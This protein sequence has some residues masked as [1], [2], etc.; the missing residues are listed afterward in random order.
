MLNSKFNPDDIG[1]NPLVSGMQFPDKKKGGIYG[2]F[3]HD[4]P[5]VVKELV[6]NRYVSNKR[7]IREKCVLNFSSRE[8]AKGKNHLFQPKTTIAMLEKKMEKARNIAAYDKGTDHENDMVEEVFIFAKTIDRWAIPLQRMWRIRLLNLA[9]RNVWRRCYAVLMIQKSLRA[10]YGRR[11]V[12]LQKR[13]APLA[14]SRI[15]KC[16]MMLLSRKR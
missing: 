3:F 16:W 1:V 13:L 2:H 12:K 10:A 9:K 14:V 5:A 15:Q 4:L 11:Y 6:I 8:Q 7:M